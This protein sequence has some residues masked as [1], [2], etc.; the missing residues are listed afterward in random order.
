VP[1]SS[2]ARPAPGG[3]GRPERLHAPD[4]GADAARPRADA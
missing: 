2:S 1:R 3:R 4:P